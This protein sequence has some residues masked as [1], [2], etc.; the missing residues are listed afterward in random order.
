LER[1]E[2]EGMEWWTFRQQP[3]MA[4][5]DAHPLR[6]FADLSFTAREPT[7]QAIEEDD[8]YT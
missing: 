7:I 5:P 8:E 4:G 6:K 1:E 2:E 3:P